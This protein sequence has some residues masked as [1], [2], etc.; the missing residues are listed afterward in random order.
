[1]T[2]DAALEYGKREARRYENGSSAVYSKTWRARAAPTTTRPGSHDSGH[3][4]RA[5]YIQAYC[6]IAVAGGRVTVA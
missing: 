6:V 5:E 3:N 1:M 4:A 2:S